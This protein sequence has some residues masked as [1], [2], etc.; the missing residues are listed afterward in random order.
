M[1]ATAPVLADDRG[2]HVRMGLDEFHLGAGS[3][4]KR[5]EFHNSTTALTEYS[6]EHRY[7]SCWTNYNL[8]TERECIFF[9]RDLH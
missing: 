4:A 2:D 5:A 8:P 6:T 9:E 1:A 3:D 7:L